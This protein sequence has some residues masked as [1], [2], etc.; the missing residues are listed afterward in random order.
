MAG[1]RWVVPDCCK[2]RL[3]CVPI[4][5]VSWV[6]RNTGRVQKGWPAACMAWACGCRDGLRGA[7]SVA[8]CAVWAGAGCRVKVVGMPCLVHGAMS[9]RCEVCCHL[10]EAWCIPSFSCSWTSSR[11]ASR[12]WSWAAGTHCPACTA[13]WAGLQSM[14]TYGHPTFL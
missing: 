1:W 5:I 6:V 3:C 10:H 11:A 9:F 2:P 4:G 8:L 14:G 13:A 7:V 12:L